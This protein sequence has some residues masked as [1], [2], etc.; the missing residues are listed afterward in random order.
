MQVSGSTIEASNI[1]DPESTA[2]LAREVESLPKGQL[3]YAAGD[4]QV[5]VTRREQT[6]CLMREIGRLRE[7]SFRAAGEGTGKSLD[8]DVFDD[9]YQ[10]LFV[11]HRRSS[12]VLGAYRLCMTDEVRRVQGPRGLYTRTLFRYD[13]R[14]LDQLGP[15]LELGR[16]FVRPEYQGAGRVLALLWRGIAHL[17]A[18]RPRY[19]I[20]FGPVSVSSEYSEVA[21]RLI[22]ARLSAGQY[23]H[24]LCGRVEA[25]RPIPALARDL[26]GPDEDARALSRRVSELEPDKKGLPILVREYVKLGGQ[27][28]SFSTDPDFGGAMDGLVAVD[29]DRTNPKLLSAYMGPENYAHFRRFAHVP[30]PEVSVPISL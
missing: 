1:A 20:L 12:E 17:L 14:F 29:L 27:F 22:A 26:D 19:R 16:S 25:L 23:R 10:Q 8:I 6:P 30:R 7:I 3:L 2:S 4:Y 15:A 5:T 11:W 13:D 28:L 18:A 21:R 24:P 9:W